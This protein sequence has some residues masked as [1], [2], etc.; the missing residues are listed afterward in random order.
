MDGDSDGEGERKLP[1]SHAHAWSDTLA[2]A[3]GHNLTAY[4]AAYLELAIRRS[5]PL[6]II[7]G[8]LKLAAETVGVALYDVS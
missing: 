7:G 6:A 8:K 1:Q 5:L 3:R 2:L 4:D